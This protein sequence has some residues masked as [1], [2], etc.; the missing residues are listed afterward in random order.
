MKKVL[1]LALLSVFLIFIPKRKRKG[2][3]G[4]EFSDYWWRT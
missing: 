3:L 4:T 1:V 2:Y